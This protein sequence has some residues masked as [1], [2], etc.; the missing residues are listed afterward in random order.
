MLSLLGRALASCTSVF[1]CGI[2]V[3]MH[4]TE[5]LKYDGHEAPQEDESCSE[6]EPSRVGARGSY[7]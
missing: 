3:D 2:A 4:K 1:L 5:A 6:E 7:V